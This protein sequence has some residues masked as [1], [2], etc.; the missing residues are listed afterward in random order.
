MCVA[1][2]F[3]VGGSGSWCDCIVVPIGSPDPPALNQL[4]VVLVC[5]IAG[6]YAGVRKRTAIHLRP[7]GLL[8][9]W[10]LCGFHRYF[11]VF[12]GFCPIFGTY[13]AING[14]LVEIHG[15]MQAGQT[16]SRG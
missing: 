10:V 2:W 3:Q 15:I 4:P 13:A 9:Q 8:C 6:V 5:E 11:A 12:F 16:V 1:P 14:T 7:F